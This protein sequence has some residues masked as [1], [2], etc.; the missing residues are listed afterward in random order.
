MPTILRSTLRILAAGILVI[1]STASARAP[2]RPVAVRIVDRH[3]HPATKDRFGEVVGN[4]QVTFSDGHRE[5]WT[6]SLQ[7]ELPK[8]SA[9][10]IVGW[11]YATGRDSRGA[12]MSAVLC[13]STST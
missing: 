3:G 1:A 5:T 6:R 8:V 4:V 7:C 2:V 9:S 13:I 11:T 12:W 10:G